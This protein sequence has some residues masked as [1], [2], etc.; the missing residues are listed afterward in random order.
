MKYLFLILVLCVMSSCLF[1]VKYDLS[2]TLKKDLV[3]V[4]DS[5]YE[6]DQG[7]RRYFYEIDSSYHLE[8]NSFMMKNKMKNVL[9]IISNDTKRE[10]IAI[11]WC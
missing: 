11:G 9:G 3:K 4:V 8:K 10:W 7:M 6:L 5:I 1:A 2:R